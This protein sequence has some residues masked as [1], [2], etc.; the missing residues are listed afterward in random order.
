MNTVYLSR[1]EYLDS[2]MQLQDM[3]NLTFLKNALDQWDNYYSWV[4]F[5]VFALSV[6]ATIVCYIFYNISK[7]GEY[8]Q[9]NNILTPI[10]HRKKGYAF[11]LIKALIESLKNRNIKRMKLSCVY[12]SLKFYDTLGLTYWGVTKKCLYY[13]DFKMPQN[14]EDLPRLNQ[15]ALASD[16]D[17]KKLLGIYNNLKE[18]GKDFKDEFFEAH[19]VSLQFLGDKFRINEI[20]SEVKKR[21][22]LIE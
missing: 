17:N 13:S 11:T 5:P 12:S 15:M 2:V 8:L 1:D 9:I 20:I 3:Q 18:N 10:E 16:F 6:N 22:L 21:G 7:N 14:I 4:K 19:K